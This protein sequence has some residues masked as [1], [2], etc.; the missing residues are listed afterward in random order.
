MMMGNGIRKK[1]RVLALT[2]TR[3]HKSEVGLFPHETF[4]V[5]SAL[6]DEGD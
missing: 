5:S 3:F 6:I 2:K 4:A 1:R